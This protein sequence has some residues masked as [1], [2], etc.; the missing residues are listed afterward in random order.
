MYSLQEASAI[1][2]DIYEQFPNVYIK[3][4]YNAPNG[5]FCAVMGVSELTGAD[6]QEVRAFLS[7]AAKSVTKVPFG[8]GGYVSPAEY[9]NN[10]GRGF[11]IEMLRA[12]SEQ[13]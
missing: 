5:A 2:A 7:P 10:K 12:A 1:V 4:S 8:N 11:A 9:V 13:A 3:G 6:F